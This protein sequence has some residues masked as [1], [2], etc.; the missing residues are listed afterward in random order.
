[1]VKNV[2]VAIDTVGTNTLHYNI[3]RLFLFIPVKLNTLRDK[4]Y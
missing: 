2:T 4:K 3:N 1:M